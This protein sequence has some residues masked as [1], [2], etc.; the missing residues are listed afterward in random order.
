MYPQL[1]RFILPLVL[2]MVAYELGKQFLNGGMARMPDAVET[3][4]SYGLAWGLVTVL[5]SSLSQTRQLGMV[6]ANGRK[7]LATVRRFVLMFSA[8]LSGILAVIAVSPVGVWIIQDLHAL[9]GDLTV[10]IL[11]AMFWLIPVPIME[12]MLRLYSGLLIRIRRTDIV[13]YASMAGIAAS[14]LSVFL[15]LPLDF[16]RQQPILL[17]IIVTYAGLTAELCF[18][19]AGYVR[20][21]TLFLAETSN[22]ATPDAELTFGYVFKF[23]WPLALIMMVQGGSR[24]LVN[25]FVSRGSDGTEA[26]ATLTVVYTL[27]HLPYGWLNEIRN[28]PSAFQ[29]RP[30]SLRFIRRFAAACGLLSFSSM[31]VLFWTPIRGFLLETLISV[32]A[33]LAEACTVPLIL[34]SFFPLTV[35]VRAYLHGIGLIQHRTRALAPSGP[36][37]VLAILFMLVVLPEGDMSGATRGVAALLFGFV[38]ETIVVWRAIL[39]G[40][41]EATPHREESIAADEPQT[42]VGTRDK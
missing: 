17:P 10:T 7:A 38:L 22:E 41:E 40:G 34:F 12:G 24:P 31:A 36:A 21:R 26:L 23:F 6:L 27:A 39:H 30:D 2:A 14:I 5:S 28:L 8:A 29:N 1:I 33:D 4:A 11:D 32:P 20:N 37:R 3:L 15:L 19:L 9:D 13:S 35:M 16:I 18:T 25:L 42:S